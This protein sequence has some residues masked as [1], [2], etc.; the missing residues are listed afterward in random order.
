GQA[1]IHQAV[2]VPEGV[3]QL[4]L[5][6]FNGTV[7][8][9]GEARTDIDA[10]VTVDAISRDQESADTLARR[11]ALSL[12]TLD[13]TLVITLSNTPSGAAG[14]RVV[15][16]VEEGGGAPNAPRPPSPPTP[17][18]ASNAPRILNFGLTAKLTVKVPSRLA[19]DVTA[20]GIEVTNVAALRLAGASDRS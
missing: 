12:D 4:R 3:R 6:G 20:P 10:T 5:R 16:R 14:S 9:V 7:T 19:L 17:P 1:T 13:D 2:A 15:E 18:G 11:P 8:V